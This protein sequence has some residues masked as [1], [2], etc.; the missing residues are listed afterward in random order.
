MY[1]ARENFMVLS[2]NL[3]QYKQYIAYFMIHLQFM[4]KRERILHLVRETAF[5]WNGKSEFSISV[6]FLKIEKE[7]YITNPEWR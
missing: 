7:T 1:D 2:K 5:F 6:I 3:R 4:Q